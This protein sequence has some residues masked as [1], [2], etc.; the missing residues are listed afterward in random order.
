[1]KNTDRQIDV[2]VPLLQWSEAVAHSKVLKLRGS[3][4]AWV[5]GLGVSNAPWKL[6]WLK[7]WAHGSQLEL[8]EEGTGTLGR[9]PQGARTASAVIEGPLQLELGWGLGDCQTCALKPPS[10]SPHKCQAVSRVPGNDFPLGCWAF[11][12]QQETLVVFGSRVCLCS[13]CPHSWG[14]QGEELW[15][16]QGG[17]G[18][19]WHSACAQHALHWPLSPVP[20][21]EVSLLVCVCH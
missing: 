8:Q 17:Q 10:F 7:K 2:C 1:M 6:N 11:A 18:C 13:S 15:Y 5:W 3:S 4:G 9:C 12:A 16:L 14:E 21:Q 19:S 20:A